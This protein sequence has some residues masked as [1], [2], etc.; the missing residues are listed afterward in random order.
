MNFPFMIVTD[1]HLQKLVLELTV[2]LQDLACNLGVP[3]VV[4]DSV[5]SYFYVWQQNH[6]R[7]YNI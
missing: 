5:G 1:L 7:F 4:D 2:V 3:S 6:S